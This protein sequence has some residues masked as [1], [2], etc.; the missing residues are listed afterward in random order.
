MARKCKILFTEVF[1]GR[2]PVLWKGTQQWYYIHDF[3]R[4]AFEG[5]NFMCKF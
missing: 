4:T 5:G 1:Y 3:V 2:E